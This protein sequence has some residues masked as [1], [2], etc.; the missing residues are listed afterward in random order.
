MLK[1]ALKIFTIL[2]ATC[3]TSTTIP[4]ISSC[5]FSQGFSIEWTSETT[6]NLLVNKQKTIDSSWKISG[7][8]SSSVIFK[9]VSDTQD[10]DVNADGS[11]TIKAVNQ[12]K[13]VSLQ[14]QAFNIKDL[15]KTS[16]TVELKFNFTYALVEGVEII[17]PSE[18]TYSTYNNTVGYIAGEDGNPF[19]FKSIVKPTGETNQ[20]VTWSL[21]GDTAGNKI[22]FNQ[23][24]HQISWQAMNSNQKGSHT[25][26]LKATSNQDPSKSDSYTFTLNVSVPTVNIVWTDSTDLPTY[27]NIAGTTNG[28][29]SALVDSNDPDQSVQWEIINDT[30]GGIVSLDT[31]TLKFSWNQSTRIGNYSFDVKA[32]STKYGSSAT[33]HFTFTVD[34][35]LPIKV[36]NIDENGVLRGFSADFDKNDYENKGYDT[37]RPSNNI[38]GVYQY[39]FDYEDNS[40][41]CPTY[42]K[43]V[44]FSGCSQLTFLG[45]SCFRKFNSL[46]NIDFSGCSKLSKNYHYG[47]DFEATN[48]Q[49]L[50]LSETGYTKFALIEAEDGMRFDNFLFGM[51]NLEKLILPGKLQTILTNI[52]YSTSTLKQIVWKDLTS[53]PNISSNAFANLPNTGTVQVTGNSSITSVQLLAHLKAAGLPS[54]W[55]TA[56]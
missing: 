52:F 5:S 41:N 19:I 43:N 49:I 23:N 11:L 13:E 18:T 29:L 15:T 12:P 26:T 24:T 2:T 8:K 21:D 55:T 51:G 38:T 33:K 45:G 54:T 16:N 48:I 14:V 34:N 28:S 39:S 4:L 9:K 6:I 50:D 22:T 17:H 42:I 35:A 44:D 40:V 7:L 46:V 3:L 32:T 1:K 56:A 20:D 47:Y 36:L 37:I 25:L 30:S 10:I 53:L 31:D 27:Y